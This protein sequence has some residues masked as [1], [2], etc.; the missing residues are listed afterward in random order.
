MRMSWFP[1][2]AVLYC[3]F[4]CN[5][6]QFGSMVL[7]APTSIFV[8]CQRCLLEET[9]ALQVEEYEGEDAY[10]GT[11]YLVLGLIDYIET[12]LILC[13][14]KHT[15][16]YF[17]PHLFVLPSTEWE[18]SQFALMNELHLPSNPVVSQSKAGNS[19]PPS[20]KRSKALCLY[21]PN[22]N[23][24]PLCEACFKMKSDTG[25][26]EKYGIFTERMTQ[27]Y[28]IYTS[29]AVNFVKSCYDFLMC[30]GET[31]VLKDSLC[32]IFR[33][34]IKAKKYKQNKPA[35]LPH[36]Y[37]PGDDYTLQTRY[38]E[39]DDKLLMMGLGGILSR[40]ICISTARLYSDRRSCWTC[41]RERSRG[42]VVV[43]SV[44]RFGTHGNGKFL[45]YV[46]AQRFHP[47][48]INCIAECGLVDYDDGCMLKAVHVDTVK[49]THDTF[50]V[51]ERNEL[52]PKGNHVSNGHGGCFLIQHFEHNELSCQK[53]FPKSS[54]YKLSSIAFLVSFLENPQ[55]HQL[56]RSSLSRNYKCT[57]I[58]LMPD[59]ICLHESNRSKINGGFN[60]RSKEELASTSSSGRSETS[61]I[62]AIV[63]FYKWTDKTD[64]GSE[65]FGCFKCLT[66]KRNVV[67]LSVTN[68]YV[69]MVEYRNKFPKGCLTCTNKMKAG[70]QIPYNY[71]LRQT[72]LRD[73][74]RA[75][76]IGKDKITGKRTRSDAEATEGNNKRQRKTGGG[77]TI[78]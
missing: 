11:S 2:A 23:H 10:Q 27:L 68:Q 43:D 17:I 14:S 69:W 44:K 56:T 20:G 8:D 71:N 13:S 6:A 5:A 46:F 7:I 31:I 50:T 48:L 26:M 55:G 36:V 32:M 78:Y 70:P 12:N 75:F 62:G 35:M 19:I 21:R 33:H 58:D 4:T 18:K 76:G 1:G 74:D 28:V 29:D 37:W 61:A 52:A 30:R 42:M 49:P 39:K 40:A 59:T 15:C 57:E 65:M 25:S 24:S 77:H 73:V 53:Y 54:T 45:V 67:V 63:T 66:R 51:L 9:G 38:F 22:K 47:K 64:N 41:L 60:L 72:L 3:V 16:G 34:K